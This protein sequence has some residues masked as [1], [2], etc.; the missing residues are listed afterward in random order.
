MGANAA[1]AEVTASDVRS[2]FEVD[3]T[4][5]DGSDLGRFTLILSARTGARRVRAKVGNKSNWNRR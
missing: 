3:A 1:G 4:G 5:A 2:T